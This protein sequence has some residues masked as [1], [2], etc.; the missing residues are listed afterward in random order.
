M[1][2]HNKVNTSSKFCRLHSLQSLPDDLCISIE[3]DTDRFFTE[4]AEKHKGL[5]ACYK[6]VKKIQPTPIPT[7]L[8]YN[9]DILCGPQ[10]IADAFNKFFIS[11]Y[12]PP[13]NTLVDFCDRMLNYVNFDL[14]DVFSAPSAASL[15]TGI[16]HIPG[17]LLKYSAKPL[18]FHLLKLFEAI[19]SP[20]IFPQRLKNRV[21]TPVYKKE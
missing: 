9:D 19:T 18:S 17:H 8:T 21:I 4:F 6:L 2:L 11:V 7:E 5:S 16:D 1:H 15:G 13:I 14:A 10:V 3:L 12:N 20:A